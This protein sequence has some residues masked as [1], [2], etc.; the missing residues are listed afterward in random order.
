M[1]VWLN[2]SVRSYS[3]EGDPTE[4]L[5]DLASQNAQAYIAGSKQLL[6]SEQVLKPLIYFKNVADLLR[7]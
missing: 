5:D 3:A 6:V 4:G 2:L 7:D 1:I